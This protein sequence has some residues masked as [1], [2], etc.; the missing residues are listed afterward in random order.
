[1]NM[2]LHLMMLEMWQQGISGK[3]FHSVSDWQ[4]ERTVLQHSKGLRM[5]SNTMSSIFEVQLNF[6]VPFFTLFCPTSV[7]AVGYV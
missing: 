7:D 1:M 3:A 6:G 2:M 4:K 5:G